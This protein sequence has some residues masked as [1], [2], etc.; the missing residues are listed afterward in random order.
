MITNKYLL[1]IVTNSVSDFNIFLKNEKIEI[2][3][4]S[5]NKKKE[6]YSLEELLSINSYYILYKIHPGRYSIDYLF[7][8]YL[9]SKLNKE[10]YLIFIKRLNKNFKLKAQLKVDI[11][12]DISDMGCPCFWGIQNLIANSLLVPKEDFIYSYINKLS[13]RDFYSH[14]DIIEKLIN[15]ESISDS[16]KLWLKLQ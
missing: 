13:S 12:R 7:L 5:K 9:S 4:C 10:E 1:E 3:D 6:E 15:N 2:D 11:D 8:S 16:L 14:G